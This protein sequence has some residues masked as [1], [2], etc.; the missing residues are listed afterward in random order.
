MKELNNSIKTNLEHLSDREKWMLI[1][2]FVAVFI[3]LIYITYYFMFFKKIKVAKATLSKYETAMVD[4]KI[5]GET[6]LIKTKEESKNKF[7]PAEQEVQLYSLIGALA[8][9]NNLEIKSI[10]EKPITQKYKTMVQKDVEVYIQGVSLDIL[11]PFLV[12]IEKS[13][14]AP[15][16]IKSMKMNRDY[17]DDTKVSIKFIVSTFYKKKIEEKEKK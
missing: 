10:N 14:D 2:M 11:T 3:M 12:A 4:L 6:F 1:I 17:N 7:K 13:K 9:K 15:M 8:K 16:Y 5:N